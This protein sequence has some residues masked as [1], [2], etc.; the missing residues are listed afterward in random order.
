[1]EVLYCNIHKIL[2]WSATI[3]NDD[4]IIQVVTDN[5]KSLFA[6]IVGVQP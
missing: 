3:N 4:I 2:T 5:A 6:T 1:M